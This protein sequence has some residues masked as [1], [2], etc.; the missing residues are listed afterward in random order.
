MTKNSH[1]YWKFEK[2]Y[3]KGPNKN[4]RCKYTKHRSI[5]QELSKVELTHKEKG[6]SYYALFHTP[7]SENEIE[8][9][10]GMQ[11]NISIVT[12]KIWLSMSK[13]C[14]LSLKLIVCVKNW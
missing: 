5:A 14:S 1:F 2:S 8:V 13:T 12:L 4:N 11:S 10:F 6:E 3:G 7:V 9:G